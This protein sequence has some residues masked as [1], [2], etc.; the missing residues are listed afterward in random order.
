MG[1]AIAVFSINENPF[2]SFFAPLVTLAWVKNHKYDVLVIVTTDV[3]QL[4]RDKIIE[5]GGYVF[6]VRPRIGSSARVSQLARLFAPAL[7]LPLD[8]FLQ[9]TDSDMFPLGVDYLRAENGKERVFHVK[10]NHPAT[11]KHNQYPM[12]YLGASV[13]LWREILDVGGPVDSL[14]ILCICL[15]SYHRFHIGRDSDTWG[16][17]RSGKVLGF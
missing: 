7:P 6:E 13:N 9:I 17:R 2:Y 3:P 15:F 12:C 4:V 10:G 1:N 14:G 11:L 5:A 8:A 16:V